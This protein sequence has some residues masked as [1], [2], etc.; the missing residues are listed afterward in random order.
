M[1]KKCQANCKAYEHLWLRN[2][3]FYY[4][5][6]LPRKNGKRRYFYKS[7]RTNNYYEAREKAKLMNEINVEKLVN[8]IEHLLSQ[9]NFVYAFKDNGQVLETPTISANTDPGILQ[10]LLDMRAEI[11]LLRKII[12]TVFNVDERTLHAIDKYDIILKAIQIQGGISGIINTSGNAATVSNGYTISEILE[13]MLKKANNVIHEQNKK[14][15]TISGMIEAVNL[16]LDDDYAKFYKPNIIQDICTNILNND[17]IKGDTKRKHARYLKELI[18]H[19]NIL[20]PN[21]YSINLLNII[22]NIAKTK[23]SEKR[24]HIPYSDD[25]LLQ[26]FDP[27]HKYFLTHSDDFWSA[28]VALFTG[29]RLNAATTLQY[30]DIISEDG[31]DCIRFIRNHPIKQLKNEASERT[32]PIAKQLINLG[33]VEYVKRRKD[34]LKAAD[35]D[36]IF[37][38]CITKNNSFNLHFATRGV[39]KFLTDIG[40]KQPNGEKL[41]FH[42]FRKNASL[43]LQDVGVLPAFINDIIGWEGKSIMEQ[44][45]SNHTLAQIKTEVDKLEYTF[46]QPHFD[47]WAQ[48]MKNVTK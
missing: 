6:E 15:N 48:L 43:K 44:S 34:M 40:I 8:R 28:L 11:E 4:M 3:I 19:A 13:S 9:V 37:P 22:P 36:F 26:M 29:A 30:G 27:K 23:K 38:K 45:Y 41:D 18:K 42:S 35:S 25:F 7:L 21:A 10:A 1:L 46:L 17:K 39:F 24:P 31:M 16:S 12:L 14:R 47:K 32:V 33:F 2:N 5:V 20:N